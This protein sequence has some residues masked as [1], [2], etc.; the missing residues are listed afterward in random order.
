MTITTDLFSFSMPLSWRLPGAA[1]AM[2]IGLS[3][4]ATGAHALPSLAKD[5]RVTDSLVAAAM[6]DA[7][8]RNCPSISARF[9]VV[10]RKVNQLERYAKGLG[11][12]EAQ[13]KAFITSPKQ[14]ARVQAAARATLLKNGV[15]QGKKETY[16]T[17]GRAEIAKGSLTGQL[18]WSWK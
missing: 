18:L 6:G 10:L 9:F 5:Q 3:G 8:R 1:L 7:I 4:L 12:S 16:C 14:R 11:Y 13:I 17:L 2:A 15:V